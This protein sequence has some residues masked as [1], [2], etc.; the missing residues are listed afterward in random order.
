MPKRLFAHYYVAG[1]ISLAAII[2]V[3]EARISQS[4]G[5]ITTTHPMTLAAAAIL[6]LSIAQCLR[7]IYE[8]YFV[9]IFATA[10]R[11]HL[12]FY[13]LA[14]FYYIFIPANLLDLPI[15]GMASERRILAD[16]RRQHH[17]IPVV[18]GA[19]MFG[20]WAQ[21][22]QYRHHLILAGLRRSLGLM[23]ER[24]NEDSY[25]I[26][27]GGWFDHVTCPHYTAEVLLYLSYGVLIWVDGRLPLQLPNSTDDIG[28]LCREYRYFIT[29][30]FVFANLLFA[31]LGN[32]YW[33][34][35]NFDEYK[36]LNRKA[37]IPFIL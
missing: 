5:E 32:H 21:Y 20:L 22:Q 10:S 28:V 35:A 36:E 8:C 4:P 13:I 18:L 3:W 24:C 2:Y 37:M 12:L 14:N 30:G 11:M 27:K 23:G 7:R 31:A 19:S 6:A 15:E 9:H 33:Y 17:L 29:L 34:L 1:L 25:K 26:P 16:S